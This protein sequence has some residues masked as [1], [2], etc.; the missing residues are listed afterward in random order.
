MPCY[1]LDGLTPVVHPSAFVH[2]TAVLIG[3]V[4]VGPGCYVGPL[5]SLRGDFGRIVLEEGANLQDT[6]VMHGFPDSDTVVERHGHIGHGAV[7]H[8]CRI[9]ADALIGMNAVVMDRASIGARSFV[10][11]SAFVKAGFVCEPQSLVMGTPASVKRLL[12]DEEVAWK[13]AATREYQLLA[14]RCRESLV[15][16][17]PLSAPEPGRRHVWSSAL[18]PKAERQP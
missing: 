16:C 8:G 11:A 17:Q 12:G 1:S 10:S 6:C 5:A 14:Q 3:D 7:I 15:E 13:Q 4:I 18:R 2:P 9:G